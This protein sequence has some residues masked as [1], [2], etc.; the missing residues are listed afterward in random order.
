M[1][2]PFKFQAA[3]PS[4]DK[5]NDFILE[6]WNEQNHLCP[7]LEQLATLRR[8]WNKHDFGNLFRRKREIC[9]RLEGIQ[10]SPDFF[11]NKFLIKLEATLRKDLDEVLNQIETFWFQKSR[12]EAIWDGDRNTRFYHIS[13]IIRRK[14]NRIEAL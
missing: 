14:V 10:K 12:T 4:H 8:D 13:T 2:K 6:N 3:W 7:M 9:A 5:F 1:H 11:H